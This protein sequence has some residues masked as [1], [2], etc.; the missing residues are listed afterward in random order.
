MHR[1]YEND[2]IVIFWNSEKCFHA[3]QCIQG[4]PKTFRPGGKPWI[5][6]DNTTDN[7]EVWK[8]IEKCPSGAVSVLFKHGIEVVMEPDRCRSAAY[9]GENLIGECEYE[10]TPD[11]WCIYHTGVRSAYEGKGI[12]KRL[13]YAVLEVGERKGVS[14]TATCSYAKRVME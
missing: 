14:I 2:D 1:T 10:E 3:K 9:D 5:R 6:L 12:A 7:A 11:G 4:S 8:A 13:V